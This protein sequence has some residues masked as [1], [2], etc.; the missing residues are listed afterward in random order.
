MRS[1]TVVTDSDFLTRIRDEVLIKALSRIAQSGLKEEAVLLAAVLQAECG[2]T[3]RERMTPT[4]P[5]PGII[6]TKD[7]IPF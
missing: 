3:L 1:F 5:P 6:A 7:G 2:I 4:G